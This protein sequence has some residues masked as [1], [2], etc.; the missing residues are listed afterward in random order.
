M[1]AS[2]TPSSAAALREQ[3][4]HLP[5]PVELTLISLEQKMV[6]R[7]REDPQVAYTGPITLG[8]GQTT[9]IS[10]A[11][12]HRQEEA[13]ATTA[14]FDLCAHLFSRLHREVPYISQGPLEPLLYT[15][16]KCH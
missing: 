4:L 11:Q 3:A 15:E 16:I 9:D 12:Q 7:F 13:H 8:L 1:S 5:W 14:G 10:Q 6:G 2:P